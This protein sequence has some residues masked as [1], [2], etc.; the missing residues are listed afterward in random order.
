[1]ELTVLVVVCKQ[2]FGTLHAKGEDIVGDGHPRVLL[3]DG[4]ELYPEKTEV[5]P[6]FLPTGMPLPRLLQKI[7]SGLQ[8]KLFMFDL[9]ING[10]VDNEHQLE[11]G[12][13]MRVFVK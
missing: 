3:E 4:A 6:A 10:S 2:I 13:S 5:A 8:G 1:M 12:I 9:Q 11:I 7:F